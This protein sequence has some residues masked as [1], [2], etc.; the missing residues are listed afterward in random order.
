[1][2]RKRGLTERTWVRGTVEAMRVRGTVVRDG[3]ASAGLGHLGG[4]YT[5]HNHT[6]VLTPDAHMH[7]YTGLPFSSSSSSSLI[8]CLMCHSCKAHTSRLRLRQSNG[9]H[10]RGRCS[11]RTHCTQLTQMRLGS[12]ASS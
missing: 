6:R 11:L 9:R 10:L 12:Q 8:R 5:T 2:C 7:A 1:M 4:T 3:G